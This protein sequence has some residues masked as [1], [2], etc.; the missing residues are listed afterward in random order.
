MNGTVYLI[1]LEKRIAHA[2]H[3]IGWSRFLKQR[4]EHHRRGT[5]ACFLA[6]A[7]RRGINFDVVRK[8]KNADGNFERKLKNRKKARLLCPVCRQE[9]KADA[10]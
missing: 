3:Y 8:W 10:A 6:E 7:V 2:Q 1:H 4:I 9:V 5:G